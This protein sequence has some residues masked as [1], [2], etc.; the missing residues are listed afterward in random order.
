MNSSPIELL[1]LQYVEHPLVWNRCLEL[2]SY[3]KAISQSCC[4]RNTLVILPT[5]LGKTIVAL[6]VCANMLYKY[7]DMRVLVMAPTR[8]LVSQHMMSFLS[9]LKVLQEETACVTGKTLPEYRSAVWNQRRIRLLFATPE[10]VKN[11][12]SERRL[13]LSDFSLLV[14]DEAHR[15][16]KDYAYTSIARHYIEQSSNPLL[17]ALTASPG[18]ERKRVQEVCD[19]LFVENM[20]YRTEEDPDVKPYVNPIDVKWEWFN[21]PEEYMYV[22]SLLRS[23]LDEKLKW[24]IQ[25]GIVTKNRIDWIFKRDLIQAGDLLR[26]NLEL[27]M[28][29]QR[30]PIYIALSNQSAALS[31]MYCIELMGSQGSY[32]LKAFLDRAE[33]DDSKTQSF[34]RRD[35]RILEAKALI[36][37]IQKEHP[38]VKRVLEL[39]KQHL[40]S[41]VNGHEES[42][43]RILIFTQYRDTARHITDILSKSSIRSSRFVGQAKRQ[44]D[45]GMR[46]E[47]QATV[48]ELFRNGEFNVLVATSIAEEGLDIPEVDLVIFYEPIPSEIRYIQRKGRTGRKS[49]GS[50]IILAANETVDRRYHLASQRRIEMMHKRL[51][52]ITNI[53]LKQMNR[54][55]FKPNLMTSEELSVIEN[56]QAR[57][58]QN[59]TKRIELE[60]KDGK[61]PDGDD[62]RRG[63]LSRL[64]TRSRQISS[65]LEADLVTGK[66]R[67]GVQRAV[68]LIYL[69]LVKAGKHGIDA[70]E[71]RDNLRLENLVLVEAIKKLEKLKKIEWL[72]DGRLT[73]AESLKQYPG[74]IYNVYVE[75][76][77]PGKAL[78]TIDE[79]WHARLNQYDYDGPRDLL[80]TGSEFRAVGD[81]YHE[82]GILTIRIKQVLFE[83]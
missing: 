83:K 78:V 19:N 76:I 30:G 15:A 11:D 18:A 4:Y 34:L 81:L 79:R 48:L 28:E 9:A 63:H 45:E 47:E 74:K 62:A 29:E 32:S 2:R 13:S 57:L 60:I 5:S 16:V 56:R 6:L 8:P 58:Q 1:P 10:V 35:P 14:F 36:S 80:K 17:L 82:R 26:Y 44:G 64:Q 67:R 50:V 61:A 23:V 22:I 71:L 65:V 37:G 3:Q 39:V 59:L 53:T 49:A 72:D 31:L 41:S 52:N 12:I 21:L 24:L 42:R 46:Q 55:P 73:T 7:K 25:R 27:T 68:R 77:L 40:Q 70:D 43:S 20:E 33:K 51:S 69:Q 66:L 38:K 75:K 54:L